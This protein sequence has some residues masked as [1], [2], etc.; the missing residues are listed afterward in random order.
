MKSI[1]AYIL[2]VLLWPIILFLWHMIFA[3]I[4]MPFY[5][6]LLIKSRRLYR[7]E[8]AYKIDWLFADSFQAFSSAISQV[9]TILISK[10]ILKLFGLEPTYW[11]IIIYAVGCLLFVIIRG[12]SG[13]LGQ[14]SNA[15]MGFGL[16]TGL[17]VGTIICLEGEAKII[18]LTILFWVAIGILVWMALR[19]IVTII[20][21]ASSDDQLKPG[22][23]LCHAISFGIYCGSCVIAI[24]NE[25]FLPLLIGVLI[26]YL[27][28]RSVILSGEAAKDEDNSLTNNSS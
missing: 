28:R 15:S 18:T 22:Q 10:V 20:I 12:P 21:G 19:N 8:R 24:I 1:L 14:H 6:A 9:L 7:S 23:R 27:F 16:I 3:L 17:I 5:S 11:L 2:A 25:S 26:A 4:I 13:Q